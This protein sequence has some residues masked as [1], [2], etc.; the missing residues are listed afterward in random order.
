METGPAFNEIKEKII[1]YNLRDNV[2]LKGAINPI[3]VYNQYNNYAMFVL[4]SYREGL[5]LTLLEAKANK[6][7]I[8]SFDIETGPNEIVEN[9]VN[10]FLIEKY[11]IKEMAI[12]IDE[13][14][15]NKD[16]RQKFSNNAYKNINKFRQDTIINEWINLINS[17]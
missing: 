6:I 9:N 16:L 15:K 17:I 2:I 4:T 7:P 3:L 8:V 12:R 5:P 13:L 14:L 11:N 1:K 10:G